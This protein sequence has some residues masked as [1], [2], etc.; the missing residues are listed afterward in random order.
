MER[1]RA[2][3]LLA[4]VIVFVIVSALTAEDTY[5]P[6]TESQLPKV[7]AYIPPTPE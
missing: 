1:H 4:I 3:I 5:L 2:K 6:P 7:E